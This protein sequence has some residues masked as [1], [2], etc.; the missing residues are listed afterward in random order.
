[1]SRLLAA[2]RAMA[3]GLLVA[4]VLVPASVIL[5]LVASWSFGGAGFP[6][7]AV[8]RALVLLPG[9]LIAAMVAR[10]A[11]GIVEGEIERRAE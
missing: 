8:L 6:T 5:A 11:Q 3:V 10:V 4:A 2:T 7:V 9:L 1:M